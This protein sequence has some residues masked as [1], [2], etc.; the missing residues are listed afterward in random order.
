MDG[1]MTKMQI[2]QVKDVPPGT[3]KAFKAGEARILV[4]NIGGNISG[5]GDRCSH[6]G[7]S[8]SKGRI[9][10]EMVTCPCHGSRFNL[11]TGALVK[12]PAAEPQPTYTVAIEGEGIWVDV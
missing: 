9:E 6:R 8:L 7:C 5:I 4:S 1:S 3:M 11:K 2:G 12:G 10:G